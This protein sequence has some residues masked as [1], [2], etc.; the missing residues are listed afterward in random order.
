MNPIEQKDVDEYFKYISLAGGYG[1]KIEKRI[2]HILRRVYQEFNSTLDHWYWDDALE[3]DVGQLHRHL[4]RNFREGS[5][6]TGYIIEATS[7]DAGEWC[8][9]LNDGTVHDL[10]GIPAKWLFEDFET[11]LVEGKRLWEEREAT[12]KQERAARRAAKKAAKEAAK[13]SAAAKL[14]A[15]ERAA[16][17]I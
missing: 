12:K 15:E 1:E 13:V 16:L 5:V 8:I 9:I 3:G 10:Y 2:D 6:I 14:T 4:D 7:G 17:G 11:E